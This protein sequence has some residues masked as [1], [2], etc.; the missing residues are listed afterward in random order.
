MGDQLPVL[1]TLFTRITTRK[2]AFLKFIL[3]GYGGL[4]VLTTIN[5]DL[6]LISLHYFPGCKDELLLLLKSLQDDIAGK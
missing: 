3:E 2:I 5:R 6:G 4:A 1:S